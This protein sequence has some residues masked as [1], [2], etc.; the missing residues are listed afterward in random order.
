MKDMVKLNLAFD[1]ISKAQAIALIKM[2]KIM[3]YC[4]RVGISRDVTFYADGDGDFR[5]DVKFECSEEL[6]FDTKFATDLS[7]WRAIESNENFKIDYDDI[8]WQIDDSNG[9]ALKLKEKSEDE[10][11]MFIKG[12]YKKIEDYD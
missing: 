11:D 2:A 6:P 1:N 12:G 3:Q 5:P 7:I 10:Y 8:A 4:G 9:Q